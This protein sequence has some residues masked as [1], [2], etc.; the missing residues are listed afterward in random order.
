MKNEVYPVMLALKPWQAWTLGITGVLSA[1]L[2]LTGVILTRANQAAGKQLNAL[3]EKNRQGEARLSQTS[4]ATK[5]VLLF[6]Q[7]S[8][9][10]MSQAAAADPEFRALLAK[11]DPT[12]VLPQLQNQFRAN[13][14]AAAATATAPPTSASDATASPAEAAAGNPGGTDNKPSAAPNS[15]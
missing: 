4:D 8:T 15:K 2:M 7:S 9:G 6:L 11:N 12:G 1:S 3:M 5:R 14:A 10:R 13:A